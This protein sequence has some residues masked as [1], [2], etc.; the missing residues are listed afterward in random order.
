MLSS[1]SDTSFVN[2]GQVISPLNEQAPKV[3]LYMTPKFNGDS[4]KP[5]YSA[6]DT[7]LG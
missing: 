3:N 2:A 4:E 1:K 5:I 6:A 7:Q